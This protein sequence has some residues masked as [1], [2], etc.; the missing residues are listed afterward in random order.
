MSIMRQPDVL[1]ELSIVV[2]LICFAGGLSKKNFSGT[3]EAVGLFG[4]DNS[5][6]FESNTEEAAV[7]TVSE[8]KTKIVAP[9]KT[10]TSSRENP[11]KNS[12]G[13]CLSHK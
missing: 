12:T 8:E 9:T 11:R 3:K 5:G 7:D 4:L 1:P 10:Q 2:T 13:R 6:L